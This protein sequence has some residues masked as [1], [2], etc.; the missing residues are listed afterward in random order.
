M[1][2]I[3]KPPRIIEIGGG[4]STESILFIDSSH[5]LRTGG[6]LP[7][8]YGELLPSLPRDVTVHVHDIYLPFDYSQLGI[9]LWW[10]E[11]YLLQALLSHSPRYRVDLALRWMTAQNPALMTE[12][13]GPIV[14]ADPAHGGGSFWFTTV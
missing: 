4:F 7:F 8:L 1:I 2:A 6:D 13:F 9:D 3:R 5:I 14:A 12:V 11:Q 10:T